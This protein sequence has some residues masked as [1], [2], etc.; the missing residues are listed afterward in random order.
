M[1]LHIMQECHLHKLQKGPAT[2][3]L[4]N[5]DE[6]LK[7]YKQMKTI[8]ML[9]TILFELKKEK[10]LISGTVHTQT[11]QEAC[12]IGIISALKLDDPIVTTYRAHGYGYARGM[13]LRSILAEISGRTTGCVKGK[14]GSMHIAAP[15]DYNFFGG[16]T[17]LGSQGQIFEAFNIASLWNLPVMYICE[18]NNYAI[19]TPVKRASASTTFYTR[20]D[21]VPGIRADGMDVLA[22]REATKYCADYI[23]DNQGP[24][25]LVLMTYR[26]VGHSVNFPSTALY[27]TKEEEDRVKA[28]SDAIHNLR[29]KL[30]TSKLATLQEL[31]KIDADVKEELFE[32]TELA[33]KDPLPDISETYT[34][35]Y[36]DSSGSPI[37]GC[38]PWTAYIYPD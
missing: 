20:G 27:R 2:D 16:F 31:S 5:R 22:V 19:S 10:D 3:V 1:I 28:T 12:C 34:D 14:G 4:L 8:R 7:F 33:K 30:L 38:D 15:R 6:G 21:F 9:G 37:K 35:V 29:D 17:I 23:R 24:I 36:C 26:Y 18:N 11:G 25:I 13:T 32:A